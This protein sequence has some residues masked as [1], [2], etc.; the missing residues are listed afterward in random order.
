MSEK[1]TTA[2][3]MSGLTEAD[4]YTSETHHVRKIGNGYIHRHT[5]SG[6]DG[7]R[8]VEKFSADRPKISDEENHCSAVQS[9]G[10]KGAVEHLNK[11]NKY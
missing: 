2:L 11:N 7:F 4:H 3:P 1:K 8:E 9:R 5:E 6:P 10:L